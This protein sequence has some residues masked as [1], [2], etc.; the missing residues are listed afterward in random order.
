MK[1]LFLAVAAAGL[2]FLASCSVTI[3]VT[4]TSNPIGSKVGVA[5]ATTYLGPIGYGLYFEQDASIQTAAKNGGIKKIST[6]DM[7]IT[8]TLGLIY[9]YE[10]IVT[11][12]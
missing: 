1:K 11:G 9:T 2:M 5:K 6:V 8:N 10:T 12:E 3:P 7:K 4:A